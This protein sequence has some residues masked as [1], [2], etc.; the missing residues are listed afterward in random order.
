[1]RWCDGWVL[2]DRFARITKPRSPGAPVKPKQLTTF[3][4]LV[5]LFLGNGGKCFGNS[6]FVFSEKGKTWSENQK[7]CKEKG[8]DL[9]SMETPEKWEYINKQI[10]QMTLPGGVNEWHIGL[11]KEGNWKWV[12]GKPLTISKWQK[13]EPSG[14]GEVAVISKDYPPGSQGLFND[15]D[16][17]YPKAYICENTKGKAPGMTNERWTELAATMIK[18]P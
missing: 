1:M 15:L 12:S 7:S 6:C 4:V 8:G 2:I 9:V 5:S 17:R 16:G 14:D 11:K 18:F 10:Q 13:G 3:H